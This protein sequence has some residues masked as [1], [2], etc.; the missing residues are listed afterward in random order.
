[1]KAIVSIFKK[2]FNS[3]FASP[4][5]WLF[6][7]GFLIVNLFIFFWAEAFFARNIADL[8]PLFQ[9]MPILLIFLVAALTMRSW[10]EERRSGT[11]E[12]LLTSPVTPLQLVLGKF[13]A[14]LGLVA[15]ALLLTLPL[16]LT[17]SW[18]GPLDWGPVIGGYLASLFLAAAYIAIGLYMSA[19]TDNPI[20]ALILTV[21]V[22]GVFYLIGSGTLTSLFGHGF[23]SVLALLGTGSRFDSITRGVLDARDLY[24][25]LSIVGVFLALNLYSLE[26]IR[27]AGQ[28][29]Q[30]RHLQ[31][32]LLV[33][34][35][36]V[37]FVLAN[38]WLNPVG[39]ARVDL[40]EGKIYS[41]SGAT[42][43]YMGQLQEPLLIRGYF[44]AKSHPLLE[45]LIPQ[46]KDILKEYQVAG[47]DNVRV[48]FVDPHTD[49][50]LEEEAADKYG[51]RPMPFRMASRYE[52][53]VVNSYFDLVVAYGDQ[54]EKLSYDD[55]IE[56]K[57]DGG[58]EPEIL[59]K[60][61]E[62][63]IT[64]SIRKIASAYQ[65]GGDVF[66]GLT[67]PVTFH[68]YIS[69]S[70]N[71]PEELD[72]LGQDLRATLEAMQLEA[73]DKLQIEF[74]DPDANG[75]ELGR[76]LEDT[77]GLGPQVAS[78][79][80]P[81]PFWFYMIMEGD[82]E[83]I[84]VPLPAELGQEALRQSIEAAVQRMSPGYLKTVTVVKPPMP[85]MDPMM[86]QMGMPPQGAKQYQSLESVLADNVRLKDSDLLDGHVPADTDLLVLLAPKQLSAKQLFAVD[87]FLMQGGSVVIASS[88]FD[89]AITNTLA[90]EKN[91]SG[92]NEWLEHHGLTLADS[93]VLDPQNAALPVPVPRQVGQMTLNEIQMM[94][95][96]HFP[97][98][99]SDGLGSDNAM[100]A[101]LGQLTLNWASPIEVDAEKNKNREVSELVRSSEYSWLSDELNVLPDYEQYVDG[102]EPVEARGAHLLAVAV[103]GG[104]ESFFKGKDSPLLMVEEP[105]EADATPADEAAV[106]EE[107]PTVVSSVIERSSDS[108][109]I[110]LLGSNM[111]ATD[112]VIDLASQGVGSLYTA[113]LEFMQNAVDWSLD[114]QGLMS[115]RSRAQFARTLEPMSH[116]S[117]L[118]W[119]YLN[120]M[121]AIVGLLL[122]WAW[123][124][125]VEAKKQ[126]SYQALLAEV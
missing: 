51:I 25:Y 17:V 88:A 19:R 112:S 97:D 77:F 61:P 15:L 126:L 44:S 125:T 91:D 1:M 33:G 94:P 62:Y 111:F 80:D 124:K 68:A 92:L 119:E 9:W 42:R 82:G 4:A 84:Q 5:A 55:L 28:T 8:K 69:E 63:A 123:R 36:I 73:G 54:Y 118:F 89:V 14:A 116:G 23:S 64:R 10:S 11:L 22:A 13:F 86:A 90:A 31:W 3:F 71:L 34:L 76:Q 79:I 78:L 60:N 29:K 35:V 74:A 122:V 39:S 66:S 101:T 99:R 87:Q 81:N 104:F 106:E 37:N 67:K 103:K 93:M 48:E 18:I 109:R 40:T 102:F 70:A 6:L 114:D 107:K 16:A 50:A 2:E 96:P 53:G 65:A 98:V 115:I 85:S 20:V 95:Y 121:L 59:L 30:L 27:W 45:P 120:Y 49:Q 108:A 43:Q 24:Y 47:G 38:V 113:P 58:S 7:G 83:H 41:L 105:V 46:I 110:I 21:A 56:V 52:S 100:T 72:A 32:G 26:R 57:A 117:Q 12:S 75:G